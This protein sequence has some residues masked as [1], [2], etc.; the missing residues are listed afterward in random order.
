[1]KYKLDEGRPFYKP[2]T[3]PQ[4]FDHYV[5]QVH[6]DWQ[7]ERLQ[8]TS[9]VPDYKHK[10]TPIE[11]EFIGNILKLFTQMDVDVAGSYIKHFLPYHKLPE[12]RM[13]LL[14]A[15]STEALHIR[16][17]AHLN[18]TLGIPEGVYQ[19]FLNIKEMMDKHQV[20]AMYDELSNA[21]SKNVAVKHMVLGGGGEGIMLFG[22]FIMLL[23]FTRHNLMK[24]VGTVVGWSIKDEDAHVE[25]HQMCFEKILEENSHLFTR[26]DIQDYVNEA[27]QS[28]V[29]FECAFIDACY[30]GQTIRGLNQEM[31][32]DYVKYVANTRLQ[33]F[34]FEVLYPEHQNLRSD[35]MWVPEQLTLIAHTGFFETVPYDY[36]H[37]Y[38]GTWLDYWKE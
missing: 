33:Q 7:V 5:K 2:F 35:M 38:K 26:K 13:A 34:G 25:L 24:D 17:Y 9:D 32:K 10:L 23:N 36:S 14:R 30:N 11:R 22:S 1:M 6:M 28:M 29:Q 37:G 18:D 20:L 21:E 19:E 8:M 31:V 12:V 16:A 27:I 3:Y 4:F 15:S